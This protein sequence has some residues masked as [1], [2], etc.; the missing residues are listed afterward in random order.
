MGV[1]LIF[2]FQVKSLTSKIC[3][4]SRVCNDIDMKFESLS[5]LCKKIRIKSKLFDDNSMSRNYDVIVIFPIY[6]QLGAVR[7]LDSG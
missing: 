6:G 7:K 4:N 5:K 2:G 3:H 1:F